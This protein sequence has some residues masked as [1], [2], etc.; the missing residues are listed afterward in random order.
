MHG[1]SVCAL[2]IDRLG[3]SDDDLPDRKV[4]LDE[5]FE[6]FRRAGTIRIDVF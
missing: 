2:T 4:V 3:R 5:D 1:T 6:E